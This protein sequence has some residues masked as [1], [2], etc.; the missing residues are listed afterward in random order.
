MRTGLIGRKLGMTQ[1]FSEDGQRLPVTLLQVGPCRVVTTKT[2]EKHGYEAV[3]L[4]FE[5]AKSSRVN[6]PQRTEFAKA[7]VPPQRVLLEFR[8]NDASGYQV[9]QTL[10]ADYFQV[11]GL[12]DIAGRTIGRG[13]AGVMKRWGFKGGN[14][15]HGAHKVHRSPGSIGQNQSPGRVYKNKKMAGHMGDA[16]VTVQNLRITNVDAE[17][18]LLA[19]MG[20]VPGPAGSVVTVRDAVKKVEQSGNDQK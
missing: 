2:T 4:G 7:G 1:I 19:V 5:E 11:N 10:T 15:S 12:V 16:R 9:G 3:Q 18:H 14:A 17:K 6:K 8:V 20:S 13:F